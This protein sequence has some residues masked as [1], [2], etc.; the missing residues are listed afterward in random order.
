MALEM[1]LLTDGQF[2][3][4]EWKVILDTGPNWCPKIRQEVETR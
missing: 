4:I 3:D 2:K 1:G